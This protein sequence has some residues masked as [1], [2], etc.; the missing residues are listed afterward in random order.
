[1]KQC[2]HRNYIKGRENGCYHCTQWANIHD[3]HRYLNDLPKIKE[4]DQPN[5]EGVGSTAT[6]F[7]NSPEAKGEK[8]I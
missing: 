6:R 2:Q 5:W 8:K 7:P 4:E 3:A 1:M